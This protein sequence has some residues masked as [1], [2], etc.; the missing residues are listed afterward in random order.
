MVSQT[1]SIASAFTRPSL[2]LLLHLARCLGERC[3]FMYWHLLLSLFLLTAPKE[4]VATQIALPSSFPAVAHLS[5]CPIGWLPLSWLELVPAEWWRPTISRQVF[6]VSLLRLGG[7][8]CY[9]LW[10]IALPD[11]VETVFSPVASSDVLS[12][13]GQIDQKDLMGLSA[14]LLSSFSSVSFSKNRPM[15][16]AGC[17]FSTLG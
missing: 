4:V 12:R 15:R 16:V 8:Q 1:L 13:H 9:R 10:L 14:Q 3:L 17:I 5:P 6:P 11:A 2:P 7:G